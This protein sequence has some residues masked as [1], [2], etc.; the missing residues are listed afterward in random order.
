MNIQSLKLNCPTC[1]AWYST[2]T[3]PESRLVEDERYGFRTVYFCNCRNVK[4]ELQDA[5]EWNILTPYEEM[6]VELLKEE[7]HLAEVRVKDLK[8]KISDIT[9]ETIY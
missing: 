8:T 3:A 7:L 4:T 2:N 6:R 9:G 5:D 1:D